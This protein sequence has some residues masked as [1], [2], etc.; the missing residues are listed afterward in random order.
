MTT[1]EQAR[2]TAQPATLAW[3]LVALL[4]DTVIAIALIFVIS[5]L[6]LVLMPDHRPVEPGSLAAYAVFAG[7]WGAIGAYAVVSWRRGGQTIGM[8]PWRLMI[9]NQQGQTASWY[10]LCL[11]FLLVSVSLGLVMLWCLVDAQRRGLHDI[12]A[13]TLL[14][15]IDAKSA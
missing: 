3:R 12:A 1:T 15:R 13:G 8:K 4:Y 5:V 9:T 11:R 10:A 2:Q 14:L 6:S 7:I